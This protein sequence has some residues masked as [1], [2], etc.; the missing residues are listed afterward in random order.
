MITRSPIFSNIL[1]NKKGL[2]WVQ[3]LLSINVFLLQIFI[4]Y[5]VIHSPWFQL[6]LWTKVE[7]YL[8]FIIF[9]SDAI[10]CLP[11]KHWICISAITFLIPRF[12]FLLHVLFHTIPFIF[13]S[14]TIYSFS[15]GI[16]FSFSLF[17]ACVF[18]L[19]FPSSLLMNS[20]FLFVGFQQICG[21]TWL[22]F[23]DSDFFDWWSSV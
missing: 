3:T 10:F 17:S 11:T 19:N 2:W 15:E 21:D 23:M 9:Y 5:G 14:Y 4:K 8:E 18:L 16:Q 12:S 7:L 13:Y 20:S 6:Q 1:F 22:F